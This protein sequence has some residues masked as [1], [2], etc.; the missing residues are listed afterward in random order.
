MSYN[1]LINNIKTDISKIKNND[2][3]QSIWNQVSEEFKNMTEEIVNKLITRKNDLGKING[4]NL[5]ILMHTQEFSEQFYDQE[6]IKELLDTDCTDYCKIN[7]C[8]IPL[9]QDFW[10]TLFYTHQ[11]FFSN[12]YIR[13]NIEHFIDDNY[14]YQRYQEVP[15]DI[16]EKYINDKRLKS[17]NFYD[18]NISLDFALKY[19]KIIPNKIR[20]NNMIHIDGLT[21]E[22]F[23]E[24]LECEKLQDS[25]YQNTLWL[26]VGAYNISEKFILQNLEFINKNF[27]N[28][29]V[30]DIINCYN[31][32]WVFIGWNKINY[33]EKLYQDNIEYIDLNL[34][35]KKTTI[36]KHDNNS[37]F[38]K[39]FIKKYWNYNNKII[40][41]KY[42]LAQKNIINMDDF[43][44]NLITKKLITFTDLSN[45]KNIS[46]NIIKKYKDKLNLEYIIYYNENIDLDFFQNC[47][48]KEFPNIEIGI[49]NYLNIDNA[50]EN[51]IN[52][53]IN[54][55]Y[56]K[57]D[58]EDIDYYYVLINDIIKEFPEK[59][60]EKIKNIVC[61]KY[62][63]DLISKSDFSQ[64][65]SLSDESVVYRHTLN[66]LLRKISKN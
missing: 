37:Q 46:L 52:F 12:D 17:I 28:D 59:Y 53:F 23:K 49:S 56:K 26:T 60:S 22:I 63:S 6:Y 21:E 58:K 48:L 44:E 25:I 38:S 36:F 41:F 57:Y 39:E 10:G 61:E 2:Y 13:K 50:S 34:L 32:P 65:V 64:I 54:E 11:W 15:I 3:S 45:C 30:E 62:K 33:S 31:S 40:N 29:E 27:D 20:L 14:S 35:F 51:N 55:Y 5:V 9:K 47:I 24:L 19:I 66:N 7:K 1:D 42:L 8:E 43:V 16:Y 4:L 18:Q